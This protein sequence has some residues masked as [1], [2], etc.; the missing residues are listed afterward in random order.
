[1]SQVSPKDEDTTTKC[2]GSDK[3]HLISDHKPHAIIVEMDAEKR[4]KNSSV[5]ANVWNTN[6]ADLPSA[7]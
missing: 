7:K 5:Y 2:D 1:M 4:L 3:K 6:S